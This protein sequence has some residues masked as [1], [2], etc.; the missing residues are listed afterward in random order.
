MK[1]Y[2]ALSVAPVS[3][4]SSLR[5]KLSRA[6]WPDGF[7][8]ALPTVTIGYGGSSYA[9]SVP[10][11]VSRV[12]RLMVS[13]PRGGT[14]ECHLIHPSATPLNRLVVV[15]AGHG[16]HYFDEATG[17]IDMTQALLQAGYHVLGCCMPVDGYN[18]VQSY[19]LA[20]GSPVTIVGHNFSALESD[21]VHPLRFF[22]EGA[23]ISLNHA[24]PALLPK[25]VDMTGISGGGWTTDFVAALDR[26]IQY[27]APVFGSLPFTLRPPGD[28]GDW[29]QF[30]ARSWWTLLGDAPNLYTLGCYEF[31]RKRLQ[32]L[33]DADPVFPVATVH[34]QV[35]A[36]GA[37][38]D[39]VAPGQHEIFIDATTSSHEYS[40]AAVTEIMTLLQR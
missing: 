30:A 38:I 23:I 10:Q 35:A 34:T 13:L 27:S 31:G 22:I 37:V 4:W 18:A 7:P 28:L 19:Q 6:V 39:A 29:E 40:A 26:R 2:R 5:G 32:V 14:S 16:I 9:S 21:G 12:D 33:G 11:D 20:S 8:T 3:K 25:S 15:H 17:M 36:Y 24:I 1:P